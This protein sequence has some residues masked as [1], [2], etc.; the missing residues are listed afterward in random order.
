MPVLS[1]PQPVLRVQSSGALQ[2]IT[3]VE[4]SKAA[5]ALLGGTDSFLPPLTTSL[6]GAD[7]DVHPGNPQFPLSTFTPAENQQP[8][9]PQMEKVPA[10]LLPMQGEFIPGFWTPI[11]AGSG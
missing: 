5:L 2:T 8:Q 7:G 6:G 11:P 3:K 9:M 4:V 10:L 1:Y